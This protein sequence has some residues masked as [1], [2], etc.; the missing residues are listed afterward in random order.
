MT[1]IEKYRKLSEDQKEK[2]KHVK[3]EVGLNNFLLEMNATLSDEEKR[4]VLEYLQT[5]NLPLTIEIL[6]DVAGGKIV[7]SP[8]KESNPEIIS[9]SG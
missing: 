8:K 5:G 3:D 9:K 7:C 6:A 4:S 1:L 2:L